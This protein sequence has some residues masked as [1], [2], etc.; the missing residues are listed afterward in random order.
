LFDNTNV[1]IITLGLSEIWYDKKTG[2]VFWRSVSKQSFN[3]DRHGF[4]VCTFSETKRNIEEILEAYNSGSL[5]IG[6]E[7]FEPPLHENGLRKISRLQ[8]K[9][10]LVDYK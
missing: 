8:N 3:P 5:H 6:T 10:D 7:R 4:R 1:F 2:D 9:P